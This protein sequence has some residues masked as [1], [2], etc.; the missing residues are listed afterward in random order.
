MTSSEKNVSFEGHGCFRKKVSATAT[1][2]GVKDRKTMKVS[3]LAWRRRF[4]KEERCR[5]ELLGCLHSEGIVVQKPELSKDPDAE[6]RAGTKS[7]AYDEA[8]GGVVLLGRL[9][10]DRGHR[11]FKEI[12]ELLEADEIKNQKMNYNQAP[13]ARMYNRKQMKFRKVWRGRVK[14]E[15]GK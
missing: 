4:V 6:G 5:K 12:S 7:V 1:R 15:W 10:P 13:E 8:A 2:S 11:E 9:E 14:M 3:T